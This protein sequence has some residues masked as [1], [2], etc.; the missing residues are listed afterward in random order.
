MATTEPA[1]TSV[2]IVLTTLCVTRPVDTARRPVKYHSS[3]LSANH[4]RTKS[5]NCC[6]YKFYCVFF[7][8]SSDRSFC[9]FVAVVVVI[10]VVV[11]F[12]GKGRG[13]NFCF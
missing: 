8:A 13:F 10:V 9:S 2:V 5:E 4:V 3:L 7:A 1:V 12:W 6:F 11:V